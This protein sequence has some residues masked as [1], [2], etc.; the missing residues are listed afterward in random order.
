MCVCVNPDEQG[1]CQL[2]ETSNSSDTPL[3]QAVWLAAWFGA[4]FHLTF[5]R[6]AAVSPGQPYPAAQGAGKAVHSSTH[7]SPQL[8][9]GGQ[10]LNVPTVPHD[11]A[12]QGQ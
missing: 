7:S 12:C 1:V 11:P 3:P 4:A 8:L 2:H 6:W 5:L 9:F 10:T